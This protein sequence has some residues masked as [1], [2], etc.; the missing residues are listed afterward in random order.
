[1]AR[2]AGTGSFLPRHIVDDAE[3]SEPRFRLRGG[4]KSR[5]HASPDESAVHMATEAAWRALDRAGITGPQVDLVIG[6]SGMPDFLYPKDTN[7][8]IGALGAS[9]AAAWTLDTACASAISALSAAD[10]MIAAGRAHTVLIVQTMH[11]VNRGID[12]D[13]TDYSSIGDGAAALVVTRSETG[14]VAGVVERTD[15]NGF[16]FVQLRSPFATG[17]PEHIVFSADPKYREYFG[18]TV[19]G[20]VREL[21]EKAGRTADDVTWFVPHQVGPTLLNVWCDQLGL[22]PEKLLHTFADTANMSAANIPH[23]LDVYMRDGHIKSGDKLLL[24]APGAGMHLG[25]MLW[26]VA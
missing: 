21:F 26:D 20:V 2:I 22:A 12:R 25:A 7:V 13:N 15:P 5:H 16:D 18:V 14:G 10:A 8:L 11:W 6:Y 17:Q 9:H 4:S 3:F 24:F 23:I 19:L 1:M